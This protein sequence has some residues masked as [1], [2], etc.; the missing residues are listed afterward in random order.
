MGAPPA[1]PTNLAVSVAGSTATFSWTPPASGGAPT[2]YTLQAGTSPGFSALVA[3]LA[4]P[5]TAT[6]FSVPDIPAGTY[7]VRLVA[8]SSGGTS[9]PSNEVT[10]TVAGA[11]APGAPTL[12]ATATGSTVNVSWTA[13]SGGTP[14]GYTLRAST[15]PGGAPI[16]TLP[17][18][19]TTA[20]FTDVPSGTYYL[21]LTAS[22]ATGTSAASN[23]VTVTV[24]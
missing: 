15:T 17:V 19:G 22:N 8:Q 4:L 24:P 10:V 12:A 5:A 1:A 21:T 7:Y 3:S 2:G 23:Q 11:A 9:G 18:S 14:T 6:S 13:G 20:T 16:A